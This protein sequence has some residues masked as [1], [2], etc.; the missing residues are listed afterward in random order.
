MVVHLHTI[1]GSFHGFDVDPYFWVLEL[2]NDSVTSLV[3]VEIHPC[4]R[5]QGPSDSIWAYLNL[6]HDPRIHR[7]RQV[8]GCIKIELLDRHNLS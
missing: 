4:P 5:V 7:F 2:D 6:M 3:K 8:K 1:L